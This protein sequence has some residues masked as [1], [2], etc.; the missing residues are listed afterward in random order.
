MDDVIRGLVLV[1][2]VTP[3]HANYVIA[4]KTEPELARKVG[5]GDTHREEVL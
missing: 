3:V 4:H 5:V 2:T 1:G